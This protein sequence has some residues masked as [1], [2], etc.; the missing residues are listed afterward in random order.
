MTPNG[1]GWRPRYD[2]S[3]TDG[4]GLGVDLRLSDVAPPALG[5]AGIPAFTQRDA[6]RVT[7]AAV[8]NRA[9]V[10]SYDVRLRRGSATTA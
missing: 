2:T 6:Q 4:D 10:A 3:T 9:G 1:L 5:I 8:D 7:F